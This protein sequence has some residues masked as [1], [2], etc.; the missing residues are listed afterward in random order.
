MTRTE[1]AAPLLRVLGA[2]RR[3]RLLRI[4][5]EQ[6]ELCVCELVDALKLPQY[7]VSRH[8]A[9][10]RKAG[11][12]NDQ[13]EGLWAFYSIAESTRRDPFMGGLLELIDKKVGGGKQ[14]ANVSLRLQQRLGIRVGGQCVVGCQD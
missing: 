3:L 11:L 12:V 13:R 4:L 2:V 9:A 8:L 6:K 7:E 14:S 1:Q 5:Q 10:L